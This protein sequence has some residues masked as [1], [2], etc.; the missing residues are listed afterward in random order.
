VSAAWL[1]VVAV[2][3]ATIAIKGAGPLLL[4]GR[5]LPPR[6]AG[7]VELLAPTLLAALVATAVLADGKRL[8]LDERV[9][10]LAAAAVALW[11]RAPL[12]A[13]VAAA[14]ATTALVRAMT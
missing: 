9:A 4:G 8:V 5:P 14:A 13:V 6:L 11:L 1:A 2:G 12:L 10:G 3:V 7:V